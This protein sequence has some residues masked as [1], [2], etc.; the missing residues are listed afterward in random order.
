MK[1]TIV[2][3]LCALFLLS[4]TGCQGDVRSARTRSVHS[5]IYSQEDIEQAIE[6]IKSDFQKNWKGCKLLEIS[7]AGDEY[8]RRFL[9]AEPRKENKDM[10]VLLSSYHV[11]FSGGNG[12][13]N[14][15]FTYE[16]W[17]WILVRT[18]GGE[19]VHADHGY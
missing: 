12:S 8:N 15:N 16:D 10:I 18:N 1:K 19:W 4:L 17:N 3:L 14:T 5:E 13:L 6:V 9:G 7:Y 11:G 2:L